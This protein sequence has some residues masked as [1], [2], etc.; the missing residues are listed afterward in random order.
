VFT[1][2]NCPSKCNADSYAYEYTQCYTNGYSY[3]IQAR[4]N[5]QRVIGRAWKALEDTGFIEEPDPDNGKN[6]EQNEDL[7]NETKVPGIRT[8]GLDF[9]RGSHFWIDQWLGPSHGDHSL[10]H[11]ENHTV[12]VA[13]VLAV[14]CFFLAARCTF[15]KG[16]DRF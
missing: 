14:G 10:P 7:Q 2:A 3:S 16:S 8:P 13:V 15:V 11:T 9:G 4:S 5:V 12:Q 6:G 1:N